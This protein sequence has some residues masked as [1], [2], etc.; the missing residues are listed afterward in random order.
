MLNEVIS[1]HVMAYLSMS[2]H[3]PSCHV[4]SDHVKGSEVKSCQIKLND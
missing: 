1:C 3:V 2:C 4:V